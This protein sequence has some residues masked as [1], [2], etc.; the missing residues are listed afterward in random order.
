MSIAV[1][2]WVAHHARFKPTAKSMIDLAS[3]R[4]FTYGDM[5]DRV[6]RAAGMLRAHNI[7]QGDRVAFLMMNS[8][9]LL[10]VIFACWRI[11]AVCVALNF[12]LTPVELAFI[13]NNSETSLLIYDDVFEAATGPLKE[14]TD[15]THYVNTDCMGG[16]SAYERGLAGA[17]PVTEMV[18]QTLDDHALLMYSS[19]TTGTPKGVIITHGMMY[20]APASGAR[21]GG[22]NPDNVTL[23]NMPLFHIGALNVTGSPT[24]WIGGTTVIMRIFDPEATL[25]AIHDPAL[26]ITTLFMVP[27]AY[28]V[29]RALPKVQT[30]DFSRIRN[31]I[32]GAETVPTELVDWWYERGVIIQEGYGMTETSGAGCILMKEDIPSRVG[33]AGRSLMHSEIR[34]VDDAGNTCAP[35]VPGE[36]WFRG[37]AVTPGYWKRPEANKESFV[38]EWFRSGDIGRMDKDGYIYIDDR[39]KDMYISGGENVYPAELENYLHQLPQI[40]EVAVIGVPDSK[41]GETGCVVA[42]IKADCDLCLADVTAHIDGKMS[43]YKWPRHIHL[44]EALPRNATGKV[45]KFELRDSVTGALDLF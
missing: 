35:N 29:M 32:T 12:R 44:M 13:L 30:T 23:S 6:G 14:I 41:W 25:D 15:V 45:L 21:A 40:A 1:N 28:N 11:G 37:A 38:G 33:S 5:H 36:L 18:S 17:K 43:K 26:G 8:S 22:M 34:V 3:R 4:T 24:I 20:F 9:D 7:Q 39:M 31:A 19:G 2:D 27:A 42:V 10:E 16:D